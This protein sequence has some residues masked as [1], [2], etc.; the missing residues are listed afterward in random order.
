MNQI[1]NNNIKRSKLQDIL[2]GI[3][4]LCIFPKNLAKGLGSRKEH[5]W[6]Y[7]VSA[8]GNTNKNLMVQE[9]VQLEHSSH[10]ANVGVKG[11]C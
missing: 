9:R 6:S 8:F 5:C 4:K 11:T 7:V 10:I 2:L 1:Y 3:L